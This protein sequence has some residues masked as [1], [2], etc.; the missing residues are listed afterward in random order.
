ME[1][2]NFEN[3]SLGQLSV[4]I[5][6]LVDKGETPDEKMMDAFWNKVL[7]LELDAEAEPVTFD[8]LFISVMEVDPN[9]DIAQNLKLRYNKLGDETKYYCEN[10]LEID[11]P[12]L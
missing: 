5:H 2:N 1:D 8:Q 6:N 7:L 12:T 10:Y 11:P 9:S 4:K 3:M